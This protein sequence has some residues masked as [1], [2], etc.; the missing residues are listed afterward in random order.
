MERISMNSWISKLERKFGKYAIPN[1]MM[2]II[3][4]YAVGFILM[5]SGSGIY[6]N[7]LSL[8]AEAILHGQVWR[9]VTFILQRYLKSGYLSGAIKG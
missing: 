8:N 9:I 6:E 3:G 4:L 1:L 5:A 7:Y 2:Y